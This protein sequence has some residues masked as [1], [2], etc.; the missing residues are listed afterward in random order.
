MLASKIAWKTSFLS[1][2][3]T[4]ENIVRTTWTHLCAIHQIRASFHGVYKT[5]SL[6]VRTAKPLKPVS[7]LTFDIGLS[8]RHP[9]LVK[10]TDTL[11]KREQQKLTSPTFSGCEKTVY[12]F[13]SFS[14]N[15]LT[16]RK[17]RSFIDTLVVST[18]ILQCLR[19]SERLTDV[20]SSVTNKTSWCCCLFK[21]GSTRLIQTAMTNTSS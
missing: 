2:T 10:I 4:R 21:T 14:N 11:A 19:C 13:I 5:L 8:N 12:P 3:T 1:G 17:T 16:T 7:S 15:K 18:Q 6:L 9:I 20:S